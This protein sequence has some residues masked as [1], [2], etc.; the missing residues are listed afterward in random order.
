MHILHIRTW[1]TDTTYA[2]INKFKK[3]HIPRTKHKSDNKV[4]KIIM[5]LHFRPN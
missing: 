3:I 2:E 1:D 4:Q 5:Y